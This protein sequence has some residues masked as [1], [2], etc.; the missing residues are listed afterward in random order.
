MGK[1]LLATP[2][3]IKEKTLF[4]KS[5]VEKAK[6]RKL[7]EYF[8]DIVAQ[9]LKTGIKHDATW[10]K[11][12]SH[13]NGNSDKAE[14]YYIEYRIQSLKDEIILNQENELNQKNKNRLAEQ[15]YEKEL[16]KKGIYIC[17]NCHAEVKPEKKAKGCI[18]ILIPLLFIYII[19]GIIYAFFYNG[20]IYKCP[21]CK[22]KIK[23]DE[24]KETYKSFQLK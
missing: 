19:P 22:K 6:E 12:I 24:T 23:V 9:E 14:S 16:R 8:F 7:E 1:L 10:L 13:S 17:S 20:Y 18:L 4:L 11:A 5:D 15:E 2:L 21:K 3:S